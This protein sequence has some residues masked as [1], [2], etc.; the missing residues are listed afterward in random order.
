MLGE[1]AI[2]V[3][4]G[5]RNADS[6]LPGVMPHA[7]Q[8]F[9]MYRVLAAIVADPERQLWH[10]AMSAEGADEEIAAALENHARTAPGRGA[11][12]LA[13]AALERA[14]ALTADAHSGSST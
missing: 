9:E 13:G 7:E 10:C 3:V 5:A 1:G 11:V 14:A 4:R 12:T 2:R 8:I 6:Y